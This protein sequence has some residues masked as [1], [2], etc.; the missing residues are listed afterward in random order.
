[1]KSIHVRRKLINYK[2]D[3]LNGVDVIPLNHDSEFCRM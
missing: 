1:M 3:Y 2:R